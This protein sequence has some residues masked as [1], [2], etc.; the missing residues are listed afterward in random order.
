MNDYLY[1]NDFKSKASISYILTYSN[2]K[3]F[4]AFVLYCCYIT[5]K[6]SSE[7]KFTL[8]FLLCIFK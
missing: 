5:N 6:Y 7:F 1:C 2:Y 4:K 8:I 3:D